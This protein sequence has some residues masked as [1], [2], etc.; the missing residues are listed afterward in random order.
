MEL[1]LCR[2]PDYPV[3]ASRLL[4]QKTGV[5]YLDKKVQT[6][7]VFS[8][9]ILLRMTETDVSVMFFDP[10]LSQTPCLSYVHLS[11]LTVDAVYTRHF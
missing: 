3:H 11:T 2:Y 5:V 4:G 10:H 6:N 1:K 9:Q 7:A 8:H